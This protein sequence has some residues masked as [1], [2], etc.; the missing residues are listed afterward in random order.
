MTSVY[1]ARRGVINQS[2]LRKQAIENSTEALRWLAKDGITVSARD[3]SA[4]GS[5]ALPS[6]AAIEDFATSIK[7]QLN[8]PKYSIQ[9]WADTTYLTN[10][11]GIPEVLSLVNLSYGAGQV[12]RALGKNC[13]PTAITV[14]IELRT[15]GFFSDQEVDYT[16]FTSLFRFWLLQWLGRTDVNADLVSCVT[17][18]PLVLLQNPAQGTTSIESMLLAPYAI[19]CRAS[20]K[21]IGKFFGHMNTLV[22]NF[23][24]VNNDEVLMIEMT[25]RLDKYT[26]NIFWD[27]SITD[28][29]KGALLLMFQDDRSVLNTHAARM[30]MVSKLTYY[31][32]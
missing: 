25:A 5:T 21:P 3:L 32:Y 13:D 20:I 27:D 29:I 9:E 8:P 6:R 14:S 2:A 30:K 18:S 31:Q 11:G 19:E 16:G 1:A 7:R 4:T 22:P 10:T 23:T 24:S 15:S 12:N 17:P 26:S 28:P